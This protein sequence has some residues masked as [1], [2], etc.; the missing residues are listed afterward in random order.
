[1]VNR[2]KLSPRCAR[3]AT[4]EQLWHSQT[5]EQALVY[6]TRDLFATRR[7]GGAVCS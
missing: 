3:C 2:E 5:A 7:M 6:H 4:V 1:M